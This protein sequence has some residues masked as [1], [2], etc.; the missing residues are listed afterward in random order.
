M[1]P[2]IPKH[3]DFLI[4]AEVSRQETCAQKLEIL[5]NKYTCGDIYE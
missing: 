4:A 1:V 5:V 2:E 3:T